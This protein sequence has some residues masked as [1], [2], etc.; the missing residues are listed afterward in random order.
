MLEYDPT[1]RNYYGDDAM[2]VCIKQNK[3]SRS[4][5]NESS[6]QCARKR[7]RGT[8]TAQQMKETKINNEFNKAK[9]GR[10][11]NSR[12]CGNLT[13]LNK[14]IKSIQTSLKHPK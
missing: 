7:I 6:L 10:G 8:P 12:L 4:D 1:K 9:S 11:E 14:H 3:K 13:R 5:N 2:R